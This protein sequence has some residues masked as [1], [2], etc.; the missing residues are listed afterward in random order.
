MRR[1]EPGARRCGGLEEAAQRGAQ[2]D[3][4]REHGGGGFEEAAAERLTGVGF[5]RRRQPPAEGL[6]VLTRSLLSRRLPVPSPLSPQA[7][8]ARRNA[9][10]SLRL[11]LLLG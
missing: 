6:T 7:S 9:N 8:A 5:W 1:Q 10:E 2:E 3:G 4:S 11:G